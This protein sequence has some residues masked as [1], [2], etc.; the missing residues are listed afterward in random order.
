M[1]REKLGMS[2]NTV[3]MEIC[4]LLKI[5]YCFIE[6]IFRLPAFRQECMKK[7]LVLGPIKA[8]DIARGV[9]D[10]LSVLHDS[11]IVHRDIKSA[12]V[13]ACILS[14]PQPFSALSSILFIH[15]HI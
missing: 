5:F 13:M 6:I 2:W 15:S 4:I 10:V 8:I 7:G 11:G 9:S 1:I 14:P 3:Q 12:N